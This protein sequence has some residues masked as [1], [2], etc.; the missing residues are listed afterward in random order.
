MHHEVL[1]ASI[2][3]ATYYNTINCNYQEIISPVERF[4]P[5]KFHKSTIVNETTHCACAQDM[6]I[7]P[8]QSQGIN[9]GQVID[10]G[11]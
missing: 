7:Q 3:A 6:S 10:T 8:I 11:N 4:S 5:I 1:S 9:L 2:V